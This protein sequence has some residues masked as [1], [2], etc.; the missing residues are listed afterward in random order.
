MRQ[1]FAAGLEQRVNERTR[2]A[3]ELHDTLLQS[4]Q[5]AVFQFQAARKLLLRNADDA[6]VVVDEAIRAAEEGIAEGRA[7]I[8]DLRPEAAAQRD[9]PELLNDAGRELAMAQGSERDPPNYHVVVEG[10]QQNLSPMLQ[11]EIYRKSIGSAGR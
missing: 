1:Q 6:M 3:R 11:D 2:I 7:A 10:M 4:F 5:G 9:L 8:R